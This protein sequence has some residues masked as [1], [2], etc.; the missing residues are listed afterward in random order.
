[1][2]DATGMLENAQ[3]LV[4]A[5][6]DLHESLYAENEEQR[7]TY[8]TDAQAKALNALDTYDAVVEA[9]GVVKDASLQAMLW[10]LRGK[11]MACTVVGRSSEAA[12][13]LLSDSVKLDPTRNDAWNCLGECFWSQDNLE[14]AKYTFIGALEHG[15]T[16][17]TLSH[18]SM[19]LRSMSRHGH[20]VNEAMLTES[21][22][23]AKEAVRRLVYGL[24]GSRPTWGPAWRWGRRRW[25]GTERSCGIKEKSCGLSQKSC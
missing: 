16:A 4:D 6:Y 2:A 19:L 10:Y 18:L 15:R 5:A 7:T 1:M 17:T 9:S 12:E 8:M 21:V 24:L 23:L 25:E 22:Q 11:C 20:G 13:Q 14:A 3:R